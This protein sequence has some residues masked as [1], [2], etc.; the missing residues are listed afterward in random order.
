MAICS[1]LPKGSAVVRPGDSDV[2]KPRLGR[3][4]VLGERRDRGVAETLE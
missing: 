2:W 1:D 4:V 3:E